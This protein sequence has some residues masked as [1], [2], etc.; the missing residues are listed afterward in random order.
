M[1]DEKNLFTCHAVLTTWAKSRTVPFQAESRGVRRFRRHAVGSR[2]KGRSSA[3]HLEHPPK[4]ASHIGRFPLR[5]KHRK[6][7]L[8]ESV[9][10]QP[11]ACSRHRNFLQLGILEDVPSISRQGDAI[12]QARACCQVLLEMQPIYYCLAGSL[13]HVVPAPA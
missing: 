7:G 10:F 13:L 11:V 4:A 12:V 6:F 5:N 3:A 2:E 9:V 8:Q 1:S